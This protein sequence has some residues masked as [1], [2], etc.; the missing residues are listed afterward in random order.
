MDDLSFLDH[1]RT[2]IR[3]VFMTYRE[4]IVVLGILLLTVSVVYSAKIISFPTRVPSR[5]TIISPT[6]TPAFFP[7]PTTVTTITEP[8]FGGAPK[9]FLELLEISPT[10]TA[11]DGLSPAPSPTVSPTPSPPTPDATIFLPPVPR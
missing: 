4:I 11:S 9:G 5:A 1:L 8:T 10:E 3:L 6:P 2:E 7:T